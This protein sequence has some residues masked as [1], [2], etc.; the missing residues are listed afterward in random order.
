MLFQ[1]CISLLYSESE[2]NFLD[3]LNHSIHVSTLV[4][5]WS[6]VEEEE[7]G[8]LLG[9]HTGCYFYNHKDTLFEI[10]YVLSIERCVFQAKREMY[11]YPIGLSM[12]YDNDKKCYY[13]T[14]KWNQ[15]YDENVGVFIETESCKPVI[16]NNVVAKIRYK[17][18]VLDNFLLISNGSIRRIALHPNDI[19]RYYSS[20]SIF[21]KYI[22]KESEVLARE[23][24]SEWNAKFLK[25]R[26]CELKNGK[27]EYDV[28]D[29]LL[30]G[31]KYNEVGSK[32]IEYLKT[33]DV[34]HSLYLQVLDEYVDILNEIGINMT[35]RTLNGFIESSKDELPIKYRVSSLQA[36]YF[37]FCN[38]EG[39]IYDS[40]FNL[41]RN[42]E[43]QKGHCAK[44]NI[45]EKTT[46]KI[47][48][49]FLRLAYYFKMCQGKD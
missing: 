47:T 20:S 19:Y 4:N 42:R 39:E 36:I 24:I 18:F 26:R 5:D 43:K 40:I 2:S 25:S 15:A 45:D 6:C 28:S 27:M 14:T 8:D 41:F 7:K 38:K 29:L 16:D 1:D 31:K 17:N 12:K 9:I 49:R 30:L 48:G 11:K 3:M 46:F 22:S 10:I 23:I 34:G 33:N 13:H 32:I 21:K 44:I 35:S 37:I